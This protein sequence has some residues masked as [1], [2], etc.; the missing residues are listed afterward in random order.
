MI[1]LIC[2]EITQCW[3][4][5]GLFKKSLK[6]FI[7]FKKLNFTA[8]E[9]M[10]KLPEPL[11]PFREKLLD[12]KRHFIEIVPTLDPPAFPWDA[13]SARRDGLSDQCGRQSFILSGPDQPR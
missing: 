10:E 6:L 12:S 9:W 4:D 13:L 5:F 3:W 8:M 7:S 1:Y 11:S 2:L